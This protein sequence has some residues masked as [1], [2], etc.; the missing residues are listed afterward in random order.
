M[1]TYKK[2]PIIISEETAYRL[3]NCEINELPELELHTYRILDSKLVIPANELS[4][5][6]SRM[7]DVA[8][9][10]QKQEVYRGLRDLFHAI[11]G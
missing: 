11:E 1:S 4:N 3:L 8:M 10:D 9:S 5:Y 6:F 2:N 7:A